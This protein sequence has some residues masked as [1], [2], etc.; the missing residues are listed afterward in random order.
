MASFPMGDFAFGVETC[1][2][3]KR[4]RWSAVEEVQIAHVPLLSLEIVSKTI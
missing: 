2:S 4:T 1:Y 3:L